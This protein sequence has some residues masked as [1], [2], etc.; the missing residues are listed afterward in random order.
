MST[1][2]PHRT[3][4]V[5]DLRT[6]ISDE[7]ARTF[8]RGERTIITKHG[9]P[10]AALISAADLE[11][12]EHLEDAADV[13]AYDEAKAADDGSRFTMDDILTDIGDD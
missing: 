8:Y 6:G 5:A 3:V 12:F 4:A 9:K 7:I 13:R 11:Y 10:A 1:A 2:R